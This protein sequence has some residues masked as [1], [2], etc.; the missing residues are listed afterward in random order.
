MT[1][2][3]SRKINLDHMSFLTIQLHLVYNGSGY[4]SAV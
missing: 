4:L 1:E 3:K 2:F